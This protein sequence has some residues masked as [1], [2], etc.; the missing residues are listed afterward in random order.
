VIFYINPII[1]SCQCRSA[2]DLFP[3]D[4]SFK[5]IQ[6][7][8]KSI[9]FWP[10]L[11]V[12]SIHTKVEVSLSWAQWSPFIWIKKSAFPD[13]RSFSRPASSRYTSAVTVHFSISPKLESFRES[14]SIRKYS[15]TNPA[16]WMLD[17]S[18]W[19]CL[20]NERWHFYCTVHFSL[21]FIQLFPCFGFICFT[22]MDVF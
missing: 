8:L 17:P 11:T 10:Y 4:P 7:K 3:D 19:T 16:F 18:P 9:S 20:T 21:L 6:L 2:P 1:L 15:Q 12:S 14:Y 22:F 5:K 13:K